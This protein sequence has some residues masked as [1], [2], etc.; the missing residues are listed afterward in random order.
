MNHVLWRAQ[1][2]PQLLDPGVFGYAEG[3]VKEPEKQL[4]TK[5]KDGKEEAVSNPLHQVSKI[6]SLLELCDATEQNGKEDE[7]E[8]N[9]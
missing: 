3:T 8:N 4:I 6:S 5:D 9:T 1:I 2:T 7:A